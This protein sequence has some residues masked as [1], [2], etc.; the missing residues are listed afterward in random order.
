[1]DSQLTTFSTE[2][3]QA[4]TQLIEATTRLRTLQEL[5]AA[6]SLD[7]APDVLASPSIRHLK[8]TLADA[9]SKTPVLESEISAIQ[10]EIAAESSRILRG[11][12]SEIR[13]WTD[14]CSLLRDEIATIRSAIA[15]R[16][17]DEM[18]LNDLQREVTSD[19][20]V[21]EASTT[22]FNNQMGLVDGVRPDAQVITAA[23]PPSA[24]SF[25]NPVL[26]ALGT[27]LAATLAGVAAAWSPLTRLLG[28]RVVIWNGVRQHA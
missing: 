18:R 22:R 14:R 11:A 25:P 5:N 8:E 1:M 10:A 17:Q 23:Q 4:K 20:A 27:L 15:K 2:L 12:E 3:A 28:Q 19:K 6:G 21:L 13:S 7:N 24:A 26:G 16:R 9:R